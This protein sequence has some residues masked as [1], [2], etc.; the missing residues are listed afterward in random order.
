MTLCKDCIHWGKQP[1][2]ERR[3]TDSD[4]RN[5]MSPKFIGGYGPAN[6]KPDEV[7][8]ENDEGWAMLTGPEFGCIHGK[9]RP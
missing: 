9:E 5:C 1:N 3:H 8:I 2:R 7:L 6:A 4:H